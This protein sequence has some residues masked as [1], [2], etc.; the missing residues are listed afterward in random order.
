MISRAD[1]DAAAARI[2]GRVRH[3]PVLPVADSGAAVFKLEYLQHTGT[4]KARGALNRILAAAESGELSD[5]G[6]VAA[7]GG[8]A[9]IAVAYAAAQLGVPAEIYVPVISSPA[10]VRRLHELGAVVVQT[11]NE[12]AEAYEAAQKRVT[13]TGATFCHPYDHPEMAAGAGTLAVELWEQT[14]GVDTVLVAVGGGGLLAG[15]AAALE[16]R[17]RVIGVEPTGARS[18]HDALAAGRPVDVPVSGVAADALGARRVG[19][20]AFEVARRTGVRSLIVE[21]DDLTSARRHLWDHYRITVEHSAAAAMAAL[22]AGA[23][24][25]SDGERVAVVLC[26]ANTD[27]ATLA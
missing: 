18:L 9:G 16:G 11:G 13:D 25:P 17:A 6:V 2:G 24:T 12:F 27:P 14:G 7:S 21:D 26:G 10:K 8:N 1:V 23:Y 5:A 19:D 3:T 4:F 15:V 20:I 22:T